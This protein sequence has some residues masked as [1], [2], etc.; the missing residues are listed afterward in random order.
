MKLANLAAAFDMRPRLL[1]L[2]VL[3][4]ALS[5]AQE[6]S[7]DSLI[8]AR[9]RNEATHHCKC[10]TRCRGESCCCEPQE[11]RTRRPAAVS[12]PNADHTDSTQCQ[13]SSAPCGDP[14][15]PDAPSG[16]PVGNGAALAISERLRLDTIGRLLPIST[17]CLS[18]S[19]RASRLERPPER[20]ILA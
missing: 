12:T 2:A 1:L 15:L 11:A 9:G 19:R 14:G 4:V 7:A 13:M 5:A 16:D 20:L 6:V 8:S 17:S 18:P 10:G 3:F